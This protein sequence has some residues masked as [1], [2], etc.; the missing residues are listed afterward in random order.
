MSNAKTNSLR[1]FDSRSRITTL[2]GAKYYV[3][4]NKDVSYVPYG[5]ELI[6]EINN[7]QIYINKNYLPIGVFYLIKD[8]YSEIYN[9]N[10]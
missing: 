3:V 1:E 8:F 5:Y 2:L 6:H 4:S 7:T 9:K 10:I